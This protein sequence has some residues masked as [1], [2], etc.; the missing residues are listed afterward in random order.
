MRVEAGKIL[1]RRIISSTFGLF[2]ELEL[3]DEVLL[4]CVELDTVLC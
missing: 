2:R 1:E 3:M 4:D